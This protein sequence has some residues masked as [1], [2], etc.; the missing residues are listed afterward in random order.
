MA[1]KTE[2]NGMLHGTLDALVLKTLT[3][4]R[5]PRLRHRQVDRRRDRRGGGGRRGLALPGALPHG[6]PR[7][8]RGRM[9]DVRARAEGEV[10]PDH[11]EGAPAARR[12]HRAVG[13]LCDRRVEGPAAG[14]K[15]G[16]RLRS[17]FWRSRRGRSRRGV[18]FPRRDAGARARRAGNASGRGAR[19]GNPP[20]R[21]HQPVNT[22]CRALGKQRDHTMRRTEYFSELTQDVTFACRQLL[23]EPRLHGRRRA[24]A[25]AR[26]R[27]DDGDL[28]RRAV[29]RPPAAALSAPDR[30]VSIYEVRP[31]QSRA[32][33]RPATSS[34]AIEPVTAFSAVAAR[35]VLELQPGR[36][37]R[38]RAGDRRARHGR[39]LPRLQP[40]AGA[41]PRLH[42]RG[43]SAGTRTGR[44]AQP[45][46][47]DA[48]L[49]RRSGG[50][51]PSTSRSTNVPT[52]SSA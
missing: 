46:A 40:A 17:R 52:T 14:M 1:P 43:G 34:T 31:Q 6:A 11:A 49:R 21:R 3:L 4:G 48:P 2:T 38:H 32:T 8:D 20:I 37:R 9:G 19:G 42:D 18:R 26:H 23:E 15:F 22:T 7:L 50:R 5:S 47:L 44:R 30:L 45:P 41:R 29:R 35:A 27:R 24:D 39:L 10:L 51:R 25:R 16:Q 33:S 12:R 36:R 28:Q 13:A